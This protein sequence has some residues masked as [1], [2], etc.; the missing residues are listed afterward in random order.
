[1]IKGEEECIHFHIA[2]VNDDSDQKMRTRSRWWATCATTSSVL[3]SPSRGRECVHDP[4]RQF[5]A[6][7][8]DKMSGFQRSCN[9]PPS[10]LLFIALAFFD[11]LA[12]R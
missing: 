8:V 9:C 10:S 2:G 5:R 12:P 11:I 3:L 6:R 4:L 7:G 1:M